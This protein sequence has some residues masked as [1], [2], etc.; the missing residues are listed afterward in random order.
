MATLAGILLIV[1]WHM[2][3]WHSFRRLV[4]GPRDEAAVLLTTFGFTVLADLTVGI[5]IGIALAGVLFVRRMSAATQVL[6]GDEEDEDPQAIVRRAWLPN[7]IRLL[8]VRGPLFFG[9]ADQL[10]AALDVLP[11]RPRVL[12]VDLELA[13]GLDV[14]TTRILGDFARRS[15]ARSTRVIFVTTDPVIATALRREGLE[16]ALSRRARG[17]TSASQLVGGLNA[18]CC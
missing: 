9:A 16:R 4:R 5:G 11:N 14:T 13:S 10:R 8:E 7:D 17:G 2:S 18:A 1:A 3:E 12:V 6:T 15:R